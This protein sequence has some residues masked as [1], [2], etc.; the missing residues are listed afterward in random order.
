MVKKIFLF[1]FSVLFALTNASAY[2]DQTLAPRD[3]DLK[4]AINAL[5]DA[6]DDEARRNTAASY[7]EQMSRRFP[8]DPYVSV[9]LANAYGI[10]AKFATTR[11]AKAVWAAKAD[12]LLNDVIATHPQYLLAKAMRGVHM[13][14]SPP[15]LGYEKQAEQELRR[16]IDA[17]PAAPS[18]DDTEAAVVSYLF[19]A[20]LY[21]RQAKSLPGEAQ[22]EKRKAAEQLRSDLKTRFPRLD[23]GKAVAAQ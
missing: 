10:K 1:V 8:S 3:A 13:A 19:L 22:T 20:R 12:A 7:L 11:E 16:V 23:L 21:D 2:A 6:A 17:R 18:E 4:M 9:Q 5:R 15:A 14:M